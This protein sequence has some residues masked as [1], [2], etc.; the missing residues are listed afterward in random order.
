M[1]APMTVGPT[2][3][4]VA[5]L[6]MLMRALKLPAFARYNEE[7]AQKAEREGW[8][9]DVDAAREVP[10]LVG[11]PPD[12]VP[13]PDVG[14]EHRGLAAGNLHQ[15]ILRTLG[16]FRF[17]FRGSPAPGLLAAAHGYSCPQSNRSR[18][19]NQREICIA[20]DCRS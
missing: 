16:L 2:A 12:V 15:Q 5:S 10:G 13:T 3:S 8:T 18:I 6:A 9:L 17:Y 7:I 20:Q 19:E 1:T 4:P 11:H 14:L